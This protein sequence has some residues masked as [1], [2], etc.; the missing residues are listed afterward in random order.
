[1]AQKEKVLIWGVSSSFGASSAQLA[2]QAGYT[3]VGVASA[4]HANLANEFGVSHFVDRTSADVVQDLASLGPYKTV[5][6][7]SDSTE[8]Q[9]KI[10]QVLAAQ[11]GG[12]FLS[13]M[14]V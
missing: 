11:G 9:L 14:G 12:Q 13:T 6:A 7:A 8:D 10:G 4:R 1:M 2:Q 3:V 5:L